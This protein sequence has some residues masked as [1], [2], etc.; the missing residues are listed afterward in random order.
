MTTSRAIN[1][2][3]GEHGG[4]PSSLR[5]LSGYDEPTGWGS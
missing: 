1:S 3:D 5:V 2:R 4:I